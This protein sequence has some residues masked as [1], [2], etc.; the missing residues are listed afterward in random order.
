[1]VGEN[2]GVGPKELIFMELLGIDLGPP[3]LTH[4]ATNLEAHG[5]RT[6]P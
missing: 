5:Q 3:D 6:S 2:Y 1:M 4:T